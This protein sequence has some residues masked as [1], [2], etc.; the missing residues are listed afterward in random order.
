[1]KNLSLRSELTLS[2]SRDY[3]PYRYIKKK[4]SKAK[5][6]GTND[7]LKVVKKQHMQIITKFLG[8][9][10]DDTPPPYVSTL[11]DSLQGEWKK[12]LDILKLMKH[13]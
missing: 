11:Q 9:R 5:H 7:V 12:F 3:F 4:R 1:V 8:E 2:V 13:K 10:I 6:A